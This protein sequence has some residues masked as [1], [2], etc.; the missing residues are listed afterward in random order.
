MKY[1]PCIS[2]AVT[3]YVLLFTFAYTLVIETVSSCLADNLRIIL[4]VICYQNFSL[5][6]ITLIKFAI[7]ILDQV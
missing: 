5:S 1:Y 6:E 3:L 7:H 2:K 4:M